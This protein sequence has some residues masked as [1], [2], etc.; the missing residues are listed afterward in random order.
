MFPKVKT[1]KNNIYLDYAAAT[2]LDS[3]V[4]KTME[5][6]LLSKFGNPSALYKEGREA[7]AAVDEARKVAANFIGAAPSE[8]IFTAGGTES[9]NLAIFGVARN[10]ADTKHSR[11]STRGKLPHVIASAIEH[12]CV[13]N[14][15]KALAGEGYNASLVGVNAEGFINI[16]ELKKAIRPETVLVSLMLANN[17]IGTIEPVEE[18]GRWLKGLNRQRQ[19]KGLSKVLFHTDACQAAGFLDLNVNRLGVDLMSV[20]GSKIYGPKQTGFLYVRSGILLKPLIYGGGQENGLRSGTEN[21]PGVV[22]LA[23]AFELVQKQRL[24]EVKRLKGLS[25]YLTRKLTEKVSVVLLN[26]PDNSKYK[27]LKRLP[28]NINLTIKGVEGEALMLYLDAYKIS[29]STA[30]ACSTGS[31]DPSHVLLAIGKSK[32]EAQSS[33]RFSLGKFTTK[34]DL[35]Y[36]IKIFPGL[37]NELRKLSKN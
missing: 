14:S 6:F 13:I 12:H 35:D 22:G 16:E 26:G 29:A 4:K 27:D 1:P 31:L 5:P 23:K 25:G 18:I 15:F 7:K 11:G 28:N 33:I 37:V 24:A 21:V 17:E 10:Y 36:L 30:S 2:P 8:I 20:N 32:Q 3:Q 34:K 19:A 9:V